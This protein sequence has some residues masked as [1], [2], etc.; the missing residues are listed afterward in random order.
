MYY[1]VYRSIETVLFYGI[2]RNRLLSRLNVNA[3]RQALTVYSLLVCF[4]MLH[5]IE[6]SFFLKKYRHSSRYYNND[7]RRHI[8]IDLET[9]KNEGVCKDKKP[10]PGGKAE[11]SCTRHWRVGCFNHSG[12]KP[13][14]V[15]LSVVARKNGSADTRTDRQR[16]CAFR[17]AAWTDRAQGV[18]GAN[19][20]CAWCGAWQIW[21]S[22]YRW[23]EW[24][25]L[26]E[27][28]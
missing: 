22:K 5:G 2:S 16:V 17:N 1:G 7:S 14:E 11:V 3:L 27:C 15:G 26:S 24:L 20:S 21:S 6:T 13:V 12:D 10:Q 4:S 9:L 28:Y 23:Y 18:Y 25:Y 8:K 19:R